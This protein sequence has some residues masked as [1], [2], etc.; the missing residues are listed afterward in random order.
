[1]SSSLVGLLVLRKLV[2]GTVLV[3]WLWMRIREG[4]PGF[5]GIRVQDVDVPVVTRCCCCRRKVQEK[6]KSPEP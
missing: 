4:W 6:R 2:R 3:V 5:V 1:M